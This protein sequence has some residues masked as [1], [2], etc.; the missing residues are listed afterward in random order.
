MHAARNAGAVVIPQTGRWASFYAPAAGYTQITPPKTAARTQ[1][2]P[3][4]RTRASEAQAENGSGWLVTC[5]M[6]ETA[7]PA[8]PPERWYTGERD[9]LTCR[10]PSHGTP[11]ATSFGGGSTISILCKMRSPVRCCVGAAH[12]TL[13]LGLQTAYVSFRTAAPVSGPKRPVSEASGQAEKKKKRTS[14][15]AGRK[16]LECSLSPVSLPLT[17]SGQVDVNP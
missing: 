3:D 7:E 4:G 8:T 2:R 16:G 15:G 9:S 12:V 6:L 14:V 17:G 11:A 13:T 1:K 5:T 10:T